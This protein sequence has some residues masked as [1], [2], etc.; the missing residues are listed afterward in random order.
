M[1]TIF[2]IQRFSIHDGPGIRTLVF[3]KGC[4]L[5]C[6]WCQ[7]PESIN[8]Q[9]EMAFYAER[10][11]GC[12]ECAGVCSRD[13]IMFE[14]AE[15]IRWE[16]CNA[17]GE[18]A[19][20]CPAHALVLVGKTY[21]AGELLHECLRDMA[22]YETSGG[23]ITLSGGEPALHASFLLEFLPLLREH[24]LHVLMETA[25]NYASN[26]LEP[27]LPLLDHIFFDYKLPGADAYRLYTGANNGLILKNLKKLLS[28]AFPL[29][30]RIPLIPGINTLPDQIDRMCEA[31]TSLGV[32]EVY[33][34]KYNRLWESKIPRLNTRHKALGITGEDIHYGRVID[35]FGRHD[36]SAHLPE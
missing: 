11:V 6:V 19:Q 18:C 28:L 21:S 33:L 4:S 26:L 35:R 8:R 16:R 32:R 1:T 14:G 34:L 20:E 7:N 17:C 12:G 13:A 29:S 31:L 10:C 24:N 27:L 5:R 36:I 22:F 9:K 25:G 2:D 15:R 23:G 30:V 3:F